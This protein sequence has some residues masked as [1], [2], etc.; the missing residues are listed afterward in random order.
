M[1]AYE[2]PQ[3][4]RPERAAPIARGL[5]CWPALLPGIALVLDAV[6]PL[7]PAGEFLWLDVAALLCI[8]WA[9]VGPRRAPAADWAT[10][11]DGRIVAGFLLALLHVI[12]VRADAE[13]ITWLHQIAASGACFYALSARLRREPLAPDAIWP[14]FA[15]IALALAGFTLACATQGFEAIA[16]AARLVDSQWTSNAGLAK[17]LLLSTLLCI[18]RAAEPNARALWRVTGL[19]GAIAFVLQAAPS[20]VGLRIGFLASLDEPFYFGTSIVAFMFLAGLARAA[21]LLGRE[22]PAELWR[23][24]ATTVVFSMVVVLLLFGGT[25]GGEG[26]RVIT[27]LAGAAAIAGGAAPRAAT[28]APPMAR[29]AE[30]PAARAA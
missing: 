9:A 11:M 22:R 1:L 28:S 21:W 6:W 8:G 30:P 18:G 2:T 26:V 10:P 3:V 4:V 20:G 15:F 14:S 13:P 25:T 24:R 23:W 17:A 27:A 16:R 7:R 29:T 12:Q 5:W 19:V